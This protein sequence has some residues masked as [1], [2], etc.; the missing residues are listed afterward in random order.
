MHTSRQ[1]KHRRVPHFLRDR[2]STSLDMV[3]GHLVFSRSNEHPREYASEPRPPTPRRQAWLNVVAQR[4]R[5]AQLNGI[6][7]QL[8]RRKGMRSHALLRTYEGA[9]VLNLT[10]GEMRSRPRNGCWDSKEGGL[11]SAPCRSGLGGS[12]S[13]GWG[14]RS[15]DASWSARFPP[16][17]SPTIMML[18]GDMPLS[19]RCWTAAIAWRS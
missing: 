12:G 11:A 18:D 9:S 3:N 17:E 8:V 10:P 5:D 14:C 16:A 1:D 4:R 19:S 15:R 7:E 6:R 2:R 13:D